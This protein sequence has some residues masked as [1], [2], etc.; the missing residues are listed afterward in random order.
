[1]RFNF[2]SH[3]SYLCLRPSFSSISSAEADA[4]A[5]LHT[6]ECIID[7]AEVMRMIASVDVDK[8]NQLNFDEFVM[9]FKNTLIDD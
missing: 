6:S 7:E 4:E 3:S 1:M 5:A 8:N 9:L 2:S